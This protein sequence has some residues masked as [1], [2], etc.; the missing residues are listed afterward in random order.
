M[1]P[2]N[3]AGVGSHCYIVTSNFTNCVSVNEAK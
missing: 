3:Q 1:F 2:I